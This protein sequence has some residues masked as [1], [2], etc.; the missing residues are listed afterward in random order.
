MAEDT[1]GLADLLHWAIA[2]QIRPSSDADEGTPELTGPDQASN[3]GA[4]AL[5]EEEDDT[6]TPPYGMRRGKLETP[7]PAKG[8]RTLRRRAVP[9]T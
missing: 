8:K 1:S 5:T 4:A 6:D 3:G 2:S 7:S 9:N